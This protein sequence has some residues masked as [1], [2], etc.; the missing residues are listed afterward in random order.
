MPFL[1]CVGGPMGLVP[2]YLTLARE[3][4]LTDQ[5]MRF[6]DHRPAT[7]VP[8]WIRACDVVTIPWPWTEFSAFFTS[9]LKM[10]EYMAAGVP[11]LA[12]DLPALREIL[13][14]GENAW[15]VKPGDP[16]ALSDGMALLLKNKE[17]GSRLASEA[18]LAVT[19]HTWQARAEALVKRI[20]Q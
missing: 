11:I 1:L 5:M 8:L 15:L 12:T 3:L 4:G 9:P 2:S 7:E 18:R 19:R 13:R 10:F 6:E 14:H 16:R 20:D 17:L